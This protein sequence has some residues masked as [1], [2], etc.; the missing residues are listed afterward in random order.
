MET[1]KKKICIDSYISRQHS[2]IP[3]WDENG[4][5]FDNYFIYP[6]FFSDYGNWGRYVLDIDI[7]KCKEFS[8]IKDFFDNNRI[9]FKELSQKYS[10]IKNIK[11]NTTYYISLVK[12]GVQVWVEY[13]PTFAEQMEI[14]IYPNFPTTPKKNDKVGIYKDNSFAQNGGNVMHSFLLRAMGVFIVDPKYI[15]DT[16]GVPEIMYYAEID[17]YIKKLRSVKNNKDCCKIDEF[18]FLGGNDFHLYLNEKRGEIQTEI[19]YWYSVLYRDGN[20]IPPP[21]INIPVALNCDTQNLGTYSFAGLRKENSIV[22]KTLIREYEQNSQ[23]SKMRKTKITYCEEYDST[24]NKFV[25][26]PFPLLLETDSNNTGTYKLSQ[27]YEVGYVKN[28][29]YFKYNQY[30]GDMIYRMDYDENNKAV[31]IYYV[32]G[33]ILEENDGVYTYK[34]ENRK[35]N[36]IS[37]DELITNLSNYTDYKWGIDEFLAVKYSLNTET[38]YNDEILFKGNL[39]EETDVVPETDKCEIYYVAYD[40]MF[41]GRRCAYGDYIIFNGKDGCCF[42]FGIYL[43]DDKTFSGI[44]YFE[45]RK[46]VNHDYASVFSTTQIKMLFEN[47][48]IAVNI[49]KDTSIVTNADDVK[50]IDVQ[51]ENAGAVSIICLQEETVDKKD[52]NL[53]MYESDFGKHD[54]MIENSNDV[55]IDRGFI[56]MFELHYKLGEINTMEDMENYGN[57]FFGI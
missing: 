6:S 34:D 28:K 44:R 51:S 20:M 4:K 5:L 12:H 8:D 45:R 55:L 16:N 43:L 31:N 35:L 22:F 13:Y 23:L 33:G 57:N 48:K 46:Y 9:T 50:L 27:P 37:L 56:S 42:H 3:Y 25:T 47:K 32:I 17:N 26:K 49:L 21:S 41:N 24:L 40:G 52:V 11:Y 54:T 7:F 30:Y 29:T 19:K 39:T 36:E 10:L 18:N 1:V 14:D 53:I 2:L 15:T 38:T